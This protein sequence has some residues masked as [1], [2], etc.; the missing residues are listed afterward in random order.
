MKSKAI[1]ETNL[2][3]FDELIA[4]VVRDLKTEDPA[5]AFEITRALAGKLADIKVTV[6]GSLIK[7]TLVYKN[8]CVPPLELFS[9]EAE[10]MPQPD[11]SDKKQ[12][13]YRVSRVT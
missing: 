9:V 4:S 8:K 11:E 10:R 6:E 2:Q 12:A 5:K 7:T 1:N 13:I 3:V